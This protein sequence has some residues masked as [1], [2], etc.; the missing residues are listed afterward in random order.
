MKTLNSYTSDKISAAMEK[1]GAYFAFSK[2]Q[3]EEKQ[4]EGVKYVS[5]GSGMVCPKEN[6]NQLIE[7]M[8]GIYAEGV[9]QDIAENG[10]TAIVKRELANYE[11]YYTGD[12][13]DAVD[14][15]EDYG[16]TY[17]QVLTVFQGGSL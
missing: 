10:L 16:V 12:I 5:D 2:T 3:F 7:E 6:Y 4:V 8:N 13:E 15:L 17:E 14:A 1:H 11:C 9:K